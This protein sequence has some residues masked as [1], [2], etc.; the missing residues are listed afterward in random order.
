MMLQPYGAHH[1]SQWPDRNS[2]KTHRPASPEATAPFKNIP[3][4]E[5]V[6]KIGSRN[7][8]AAGHG[9]RVLGSSPVD[10]RSVLFAAGNTTGGDKRV[11]ICC[12]QAT[13]GETID[14]GDAQSGFTPSRCSGSAER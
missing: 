8:T 4:S 9:R 1:K 10:P 3:H 2:M 13:G 12:C 6:A 5:R 14:G 7:C 11:W